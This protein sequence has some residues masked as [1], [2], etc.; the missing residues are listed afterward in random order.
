MSEANGSPSLLRWTLAFMRPY[1]GRMTL[2]AILL[3]VEVALGA[4]QP[5][6]LK[7]VIDYVLVGQP[8]PQPL[9][10]MAAGHSRRSIRSRCS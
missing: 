9:R 6:L 10:R 7:A 2:V 1:R 3:L 4:L 5:W 8:I